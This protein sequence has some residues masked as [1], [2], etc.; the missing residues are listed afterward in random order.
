MRKA[1]S[2]FCNSWPSNHRLNKRR[3][4]SPV[5]GTVLVS[6]VVNPGKVVQSGE[7]VAEIAANNSSLLLSAAIPDRDAGF[8]EK[9]MTAQIKF[10][11]YSYQDFGTIPGKVISISANTKTDENLGEVYRVEIE[12]ERDYVLEESKKVLFKPGQIA[13][14]DIVIRRLRILDVLLE[15]IKKIQR[16]G[17][18]L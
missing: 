11:A 10:D 1:V 14:A 18:N 2:S 7:T 12:L 16:D 15:P 8:I 9:G 6:N 5:A 13:T 17:I 3:L 4:R